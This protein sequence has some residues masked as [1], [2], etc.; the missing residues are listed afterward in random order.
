MAKRDRQTFEFP[1]GRM[2]RRK[3]QSFGCVQRWEDMETTYEQ[4]MSGLWMLPEGA[5][6][7]RLVNAM[8][9]A[10]SVLD[11]A[12]TEGLLEPYYE[13]FM[14]TIEQVHEQAYAI[15]M[16]IERWEEPDWNIT[17]ARVHEIMD[18][19]GLPPVVVDGH[20]KEFAINL[21]DNILYALKLELDAHCTIMMRTYIAQAGRIVK[22]KGET[23]IYNELMFHY[24]QL[25]DHLRAVR[26]NHQN[27]I[28][29]IQQFRE[30]Y[31]TDPDVKRFQ[32]VSSPM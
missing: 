7:S 14:Q 26:Y 3:L 28:K 2:T 6:T 32:W 8:N 20:A 30:S 17:N 21:G 13:T 29:Q 12:C 1:E 27:E 23:A 25:K 11:D 24:K 5:M 31:R 10:K 22:F 15:Y 16:D 19:E 18:A 9:L 4:A